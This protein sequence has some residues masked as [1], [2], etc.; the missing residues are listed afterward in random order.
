MLNQQYMDP[1]NGCHE[2]DA[3]FTPLRVAQVAAGDAG[4]GE[5][6]R[7]GDDAARSSL[8]SA[9]ALPPSREQIWPEASR[10]QAPAAGDD[11][12]LGEARTD[13]RFKIAQ[14]ASRCL[15]Q[16]LE[17]QENTHFNQV[18]V[19]VCPEV[20]H[21]PTLDRQKTGRQTLSWGDVS[22]RM[23][24]PCNHQEEACDDLTAE[25]TVRLCAGRE[26]SNV[27]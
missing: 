11:Q 18:H 23:I 24:S 17:L 26:S 8:R 1:L 19:S 22:V 9:S 16:D 4:E 10:P 27:C 15:H 6:W 2:A 21:P 3:R 12:T 14:V 7:Q 13:Y 5:S 25:P 20:P